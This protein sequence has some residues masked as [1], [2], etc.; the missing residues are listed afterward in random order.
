MVHLIKK[1]SQLPLH[2]KLYYKQEICLDYLLQKKKKG[3]H[4][5]S[6]VIMRREENVYFQFRIIL[7]SKTSRFYYPP[8][9]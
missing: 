8:I 4:V 3:V 1:K 6:L 9:S 7:L 5:T 2:L